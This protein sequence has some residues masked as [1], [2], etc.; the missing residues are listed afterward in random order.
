MPPSVPFAPASFDALLMQVLPRARRMALRLVADAAD[1]DDLVQETAILAHRHFAHFR[2]GTNFAAWFLRILTNR[3]Y[4]LRRRR[5]SWYTPSG[6]HD[7]VA[8]LVDPLPDPAAAVEDGEHRARVADALAQLPGEFRDVCTL[9]LVDDLRYQDIAVRLAI[10]VGTVRS[11]LHR[12]RHLLRHALR[13]MAEDF[14]YTR[15]RRRAAVV[16]GGATGGDP[17]PIPARGHELTA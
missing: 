2:P 5:T 13:P 11:R 14:G 1:A 12:G 8:T 15:A 3:F 7:T 10:P 16:G 17:A 6:E 4:T 9:Y